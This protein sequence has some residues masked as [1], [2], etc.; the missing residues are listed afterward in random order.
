VSPVRGKVE[1]LAGVKVLGRRG[2]TSETKTPVKAEA[3]L[4]KHRVSF[5]EASTVFDD[6][7][8]ITFLDVEHSF[9]E[10]RY[11]TMGL[12]HRNRLLLVAH[13]DREG[14]IRVISARK[15]TKNEP[16]FYEEAE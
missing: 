13:I 15:A 1:V 3:N 14:A 9:S 11:I 10:E 5:E 8:F 2:E 7:L 6:P 12:S 4:K 16:R